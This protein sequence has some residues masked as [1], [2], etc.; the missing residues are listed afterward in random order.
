MKKMEYRR[1]TADLI[2][3]ENEDIIMTSGKDDDKDKTAPCVYNGTDGSCDWTHYYE[4]LDF[5]NLC[6]SYMFIHGCGWDG[7]FDQSPFSLNE[8]DWD[9]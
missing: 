5:K 9:N 6:D 3:F 1:P 8:E 4:T 2:L 7:H